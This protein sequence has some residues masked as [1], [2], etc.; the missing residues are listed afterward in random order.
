MEESPIDEKSLDKTRYKQLCGDLMRELSLKDAPVAVKFF[1]TEAE[2]DYFKKRNDYILPTEPMT[3]CQCEQT[4]RDKKQTIY[5]ELKDLQCDSEAYGLGLQENDEATVS[6]GQYSIKG[7]YAIA[8]APL[9][10]ARFIA[11]TVNV[12]CHSS[13]ANTLIGAWEEVAGVVAWR[14][15]SAE[16]VS[17]CSC[18]VYVHNQNLASI[19]PLCPSSCDETQSDK[20]NVILPADHL[21]HTVDQLLSSKLS[22][23]S[24]PYS[25]PGDG[26]FRYMVDE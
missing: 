8:L 16:D 19:G 6:S 10:D 3:F 23:K 7:V 20:M 15:S 5:M 24:S 1:Y 17:S 22:L 21:N 2:F 4:A 14:P 18:T 12:Y 9:A 13:Q 26:V 25:R 11:D